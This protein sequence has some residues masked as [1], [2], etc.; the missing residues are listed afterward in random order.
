M[1]KS[2][3]MQN[4][5]ELSSLKMCKSFFMQNVQE[6]SPLN[7]YKSLLTN[8]PILQAQQLQETTTT[9]VQGHHLGGNFPSLFFKCLRVL[10]TGRHAHS[11][12]QESPEE[13]KEATQPQHTHDAFRTPVK[14]SR[15]PAFV[16]ARTPKS[17][18]LPKTTE[19]CQH[20][21]VLL[22]GIARKNALSLEHRGFF[23][24]YSAD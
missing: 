1:R 14:V 2:L 24:G 16:A 13:G 11:K 19:L 23:G 17:S 20:S 6:L 21:F 18:S 22:P 3:V 12:K 9:D 7:T 10:N 8:G 4:V 5:Q 15:H